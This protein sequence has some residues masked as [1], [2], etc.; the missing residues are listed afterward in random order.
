MNAKCKKCEFALLFFINLTLVKYG[1][2]WQKYDNKMS[3][4]RCIISKCPV[5]FFYFSREWGGRYYL[6]ADIT[7]SSATIGFSFAETCFSAISLKR[8]IDQNKTWAQGVSVCNQFYTHI[9][10]NQNLRV[11]HWL[12]MLTIQSALFRQSSSRAEVT[13]ASRNLGCDP[14]SVHQS[15]LPPTLT[16]RSATGGAQIRRGG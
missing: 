9:T 15:R 7:P 2:K 6:L 12:V 16:S 8:R 13:D 5:F 4:L 10:K 14:W 1:W 11:C 3:Y